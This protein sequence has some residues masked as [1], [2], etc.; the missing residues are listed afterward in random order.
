MNRSSRRAPTKKKTAARARGGKSPAGKKAAPRSAARKA[1]SPALRAVWTGALSF[2]LVQ[3]P[4]RLVTAEARR[5]LSFR[6]I[7]RRNGA[8]V[9]YERVNDETG[10]KVEWGDIVKGYEVEK[11]RYVLLEDEDFAK[12]DVKATH[13][14]DIQDFVPRADIP[15]AYFERPYFVL[16]G[17]G[18]T[19]AY[20]LL[21][22]VLEKRGVVAVALVVL[23]NRQH[24]CAVGAEG[25]GLVLELLRFADELR[26]VEL[27]ADELPAGKARATAKEVELAEQ[28]VE[29]LT[30]T[31]DPT[32][33]EDRYRKVLL[34]AIEKKAKTGKMPK[35]RTPAPKDDAKVQDLLEML[36]KSVRSANKNAA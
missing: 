35:S 25:D 29:R 26:S 15:P 1:E 8:R 28:L 11:G 18:G 33:Y 5:E 6:Q 13:T 23:R 30:G 10:D 20:A 32:K 36:R 9:R 27:V 3:V 21:R 19:K 12:A 31:F 7:D 17:K 24:L 14:V 34:A 4:V 22:D 2:G 16:P